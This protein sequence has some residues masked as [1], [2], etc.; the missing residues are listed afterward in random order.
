MGSRPELEWFLTKLSCILILPSSYTG[1]QILLLLF[2]IEIRCKQL[3]RRSLLI[4][5]CFEI[6][7]LKKIKKN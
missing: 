6:D 7:K 1:P 5:I 4:I 2:E 3:L